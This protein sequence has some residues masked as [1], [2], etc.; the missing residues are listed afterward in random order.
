[1]RGLGVVQRLNVLL[2]LGQN[3]QVVAPGDGQ[4]LRNRL[5]R[6][7]GNRLL[8]NWGVE[9]KQV[10]LAVPTATRLITT[11]SSRNAAAVARPCAIWAEPMYAT[12]ASDSIRIQVRVIEWWGVLLKA[13]SSGAVVGCRPLT[14]PGLVSVIPRTATDESKISVASLP[15]SA[16]AMP[17]QDRN[18]ISYR[19]GPFLDDVVP[20]ELV[21]L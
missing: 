5:F 17:E 3:G 21:R 6:K 20:F 1:M 9:P 7:L 16:K 2:A 14:H 19:H 18:P 15:G 12:A 10:P 13:I 11:G 8:P 4:N